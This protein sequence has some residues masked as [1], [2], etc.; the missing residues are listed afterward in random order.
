MHAKRWSVARQLLALQTLLLL[1]VFALADTTT[2]VVDRNNNQSAARA[3]VL[4]L[5]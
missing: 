3:K 4:A 1:S 5:A 2:L